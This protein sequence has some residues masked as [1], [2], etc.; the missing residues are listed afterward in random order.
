MH[1]KE[2]DMISLFIIE[3]G[4]HERHTATHGN[5]KPAAPHLSRQIS[6][7]ILT[8][9]SRNPSGRSSH[10]TIRKTQY[11]LLRHNFSFI[12][13]E[14]FN[15]TA[16]VSL[17]ISEATSGVSSEPKLDL[18]DLELKSLGRTGRDFQRKA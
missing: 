9:R 5:G 13:R 1:L 11:L 17:P 10:S 3:V 16:D 12:E 8:E 4:S 6:T 14:T 15:T 7:S 2:H 18:G